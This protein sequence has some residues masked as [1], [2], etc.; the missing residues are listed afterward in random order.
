[1]ILTRD[2]VLDVNPG[3]GE[4]RLTLNGSHWLWAV[5]AIM[6]LSFLIYA[7]L[8]TFRT[9]NGERIFHYLF[10]IGLF[11]GSVAY[12]A[13]ASN[14]GWSAIATH[15]YRSNALTYTVFFAKYVY[16]VISFPV[17]I[18]ALGLISGVSWA[19]I[20]YNVFLSWAWI[21]SYLVGA[22]TA[23]R[24]KWGFFTLGTLA[25]LLLAHSTFVNGL[26]ASRRFTLSRDYTILA[27]YLNLLWF[28][29]PIGWAVTDGGNVMGVTQMAIYFGILDLLLLPGLAFGFLL[30]SRRWDY[31]LMGLHFTQ[32]GRVPHGTGTFPEKETR[33]AA[34]PTGGITNDTYA[35]APATAVPGQTTAAPMQPNTATV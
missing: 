8:G 25:Y 13:M 21:I 1:M 30:L 35:P 33:A 6:I 15:L 17:A 34:P 27:G 4:R 2:N 14:L 16:W 18:I 23:T 11:A 19:T 7:V 22:Y 28:L 9:R 31:G 12:F 32:Y 20:L 29:Y 10:T 3:G 26:S 5:D 24:Y